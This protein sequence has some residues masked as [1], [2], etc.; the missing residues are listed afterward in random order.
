MRADR[1]LD[2]FDDL[3]VPGRDVEP[4][5]E[6]GAQV[7]QERRVVDLLVVEAPPGELALLAQRFPGFEDEKPAAW[8]MSPRVVSSA[9]RLD[10]RF[11]SP[12]WMRMGI[13][14]VASAIRLGLH[15]GLEA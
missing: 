10:Q 3:R 2:A 6:V 12:P 7:E 4:F 15:S 9:G 14:P 1:L 11:S 13:R 5:S 8:N